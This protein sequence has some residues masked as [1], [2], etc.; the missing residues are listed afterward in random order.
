MFKYELQFVAFIWP[1][2]CSLDMFLLFIVPVGRNFVLDNKQE[3]QLMLTN[4]YDAMLYGPLYIIGS[5]DA[6]PNYCVFSIF[7][8]RHLGFSYFRSFCQK[9]IFAPICSSSCKIWRSD[10]LR[11]SA[12]VIAYFRF[13]KW[14][15]S[16]IL[17]VVWRHSE[18]PT[19][20]V[21]RS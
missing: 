16:A 6:Q 21:W 19:T 15:T 1:N 7:I 8:R 2:L 5:D 3:A 18:P 20:Y 12:R 14:R 9:F 10:Y 4:P 13:S 11:P 17:D